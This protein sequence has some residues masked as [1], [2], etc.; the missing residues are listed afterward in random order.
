MEVDCTGWTKTLKIIAVTGFLYGCIKTCIKN[1]TQRKRET[2]VQQRFSLFCTCPNFRLGT[3]LVLF[4]IIY[5]RMKIVL[6]CLEFLTNSTIFITVK[7]HFYMMG[8][9]NTILRVFS[10][11]HNFIYSIV[12]N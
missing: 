7:F 10:S 12:T 1:V 2:P 11:Y 8:R 3:F 6:C 5:T 9:N 4:L